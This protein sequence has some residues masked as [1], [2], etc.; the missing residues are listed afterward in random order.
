MAYGSVISLIAELLY[1]FCGHLIIVQC[2][3]LNS[4]QYISLPRSIMGQIL[5]LAR[6]KPLVGI[7]NL[8]KITGSHMFMHK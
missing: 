1:F 3:A 7:R 8:F 5:V 4:L 2:S 6:K